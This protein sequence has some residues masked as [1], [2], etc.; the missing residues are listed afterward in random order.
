MLSTSGFL[1][2]QTLSCVQG[3]LVWVLSKAGMDCVLPWNNCQSLLKG[4]G[5]F[6]QVQMA[7]D[8]NPMGLS[9]SQASGFLFCLYKSAPLFICFIGLLC[10]KIQMHLSTSLALSFLIMGLFTCI[11]R[12]HVRLPKALTA[13]LPLLNYSLEYLQLFSQTQTF[14]GKPRVCH[15]AL[16]WVQLWVQYTLPAV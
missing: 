7:A 5:V 4:V 16:S 12:K 3:N 2:C 8:P 13:P 9:Y 10:F 1:Q 15:K 11:G 6:F 14:L